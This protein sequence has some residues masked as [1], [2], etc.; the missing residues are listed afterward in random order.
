MFMTFQPLC[1]FQISVQ[2]NHLRRSADS[3]LH[4]PLPLHPLLVV[5]GVTPRNTTKR[6]FGGG[7]LQR[8]AK[9]QRLACELTRQ[10]FVAQRGPAL[11]NQPFA[12]C[13]P[14]A[15]RSAGKAFAFIT[16]L[17]IY[18]FILCSSG[19]KKELLRVIFPVH[20]LCVSM[21]TSP[22]PGCRDKLAPF[23][24]PHP[25]SLLLLLHFPQSARKISCSACLF[26][27]LCI[28]FFF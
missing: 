22:K 19:V 12:R 18:L 13:R 28:L 16:V 7:I 11:A 25:R 5:E 26:S 27:V 3:S 17:F 9:C 10:T 8:A 6:I 14:A 15:Q 20:P 2:V 1:I 23:S 4:L 21:V 24:T